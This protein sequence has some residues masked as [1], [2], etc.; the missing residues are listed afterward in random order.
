MAK[1]EYTLDEARAIYEA[2]KLFAQM[3]A[4]ELSQHA[5]RLAWDYIDLMRNMAEC[6]TLEQAQEWLN[7]QAPIFEAAF[8]QYTAQEA[9]AE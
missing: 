1:N 2:G 4:P 9:E 7:A 5:F 3:D 8:A 6:E